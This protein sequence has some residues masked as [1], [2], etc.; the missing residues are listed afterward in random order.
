MLLSS[1]LSDYFQ[2]VQHLLRYSNRVLSAVSTNSR[3]SFCLF[4]ICLPSLHS[5]PSL[6]LTTYLVCIEKAHAFTHGL[7]ILRALAF[8]ILV[9]AFAIHSLKSILA[10]L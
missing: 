8:I 6:Q 9:I 4:Q 1:D 7:D 5:Y 2:Q 3:P 10:L